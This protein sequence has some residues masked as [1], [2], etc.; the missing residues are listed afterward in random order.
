MPGTRR[1]TNHHGPNAREAAR[2]F[3]ERTPKRITDT[4]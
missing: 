3:S 4:E 1:G 2:H